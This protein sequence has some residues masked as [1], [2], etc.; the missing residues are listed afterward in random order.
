MT[1]Q[2]ICRRCGPPVIAT[3]IAIQCML[4]SPT[5]GRKWTDTTG[6]LLVEAEF[7]KIVNETVVLKKQDGAQITLPLARLSDTDRDLVRAI[8]T[9]K[10]QVRLVAQVGHYRFH[11][12]TFSPD[13]RQVLTTGDY[14]ARLWDAATGKELCQLVSFTGG[15]AVVDSAGRYDASDSGDVEGLHWVIGNE[16]IALDQLKDRYYEPGLL[17]KLTGFNKEP[18]REVEAFSNPKLY[19]EIKLAAPTLGSSRLTI[20]L[21][22]RD[23]GFGRVVVKINGKELTADARGLGANH[24]VKPRG[25]HLVLSVDLAD[26]PRL[27]PGEENRIEVFAFNE[28]GYLSSRGFKLDYTAPGR[29]E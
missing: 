5:L 19:P 23:G 25:D 11:S 26:D 27:K 3:A 18:L 20:D 9:Q 16:P 24:E 12:V 15:W 8:A 17:A 28:E 1:S 4:V 7:V 29:T 22:K 10:K 21:K 14:Y 13:G 2:T 6:K